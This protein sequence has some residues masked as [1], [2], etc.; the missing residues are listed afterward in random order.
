MGS[1]GNKLEVGDVL[2]IGRFIFKVSDMSNKKAYSNSPIF[3]PQNPAQ[4]HR[5]GELTQTNHPTLG[6]GEKITTMR[7]KKSN[8]RIKV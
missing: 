3:D 2:K 6:F 5:T 4:F 1:K 8:Y 7:K